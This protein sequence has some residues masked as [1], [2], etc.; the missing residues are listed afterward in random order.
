M[1]GQFLTF[2]VFLVLVAAIVRQDFAFIIVYLFVGT[3]IVGS[4]WLRRSMSSIRFKRIFSERAFLSEEIP[5]R[6]EISNGS[7]LPVVWLRVHESLPVDLT[8]R[9]F[10][11]RVLSLGPQGKADLDYRLTARKRGYYSIGPTRV[12]SG[13]IFGV[14]DEQTGS[15][16]AD[17]LIVYP[18]IVAIN[19]ITLPSNSPIGTLRHNQPIFEDPSRVM[20][21]RSY[22]AGDSLRRVDW[23]ATASSGSLQVKLFEPSIALE[24]AILLDLNADNYE[25]KTRYDLTELAIVIAASMA[26][27]VA[28]RKQ[29][30]GLVSN[31]L[32]PTRL[33]QEPDE[34]PPGLAPLIHPV[35]PRKGRGHLMRILDA[36]ARVQSGPSIPLIELLRRET[37]HLPWGTTLIIITE[38]IDQD[39]FDQLFQMRRKGFNLLLILTGQGEKINQIRRQAVSA[40]FPCVQICSEKDMDSWRR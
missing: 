23:K 33:E 8:I 7:W 34:E 25:L 29:A 27:W 17:H 18:K 39:F 20:G 4:W 21:K 9:P 2:L 38:K 15:S 22:I 35:P 12:Y 19:N 40:G 3:F 32:D 1:T 14:L 36:L 5:V 26:N 30:V 31:G 11:R 16:P 24:T 28:G 37:L 10:F 13:D 6:L